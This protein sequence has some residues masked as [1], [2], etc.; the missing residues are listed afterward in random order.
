MAILTKG[1]QLGAY[2]VGDLVGY[3]GIAEV[4]RGRHEELDRDVA[5][6]V[7]N[8]TFHADPTFPLRFRR[9][10]KV[11]ARLSHPNIITVYDFGDTGTTAYLVMELASGDMSGHIR[12]LTTLREVVDAL[13]PVFEAVAYAHER[14]VVH[15]DI[16]PD[17]VL[18]NHQLRPLLADFG[19]ARIQAESFDADEVGLVVGTPYF[20]APEQIQAL[21]VDGR[22]DIYGLGVL[23]YAVLVGRVPFDGSTFTAVASQHLK[24]PAPSLKADLPDAP[25]VLD[26]AVLRA[27]AKRPEDRYPTAI[28]FYDD[29]RRAADAAPNLVIGSGRST[30]T[31]AVLSASDS[32]GQTVQRPVTDVL[33]PVVSGAEV[34]APAGFVSCRTCESF[35][36]PGLTF[37]EVCGAKMPAAQVATPTE[38]T[39]G[40]AVERPKPRRRRASSFTRG[41]KI[42]LSGAAVA[43]L[44]VNVVGVWLNHA[45][46]ARN[47]GV[48]GFIFRNLGWFKSGMTLA[49][50]VL[51]VLASYDMWIVTID[52][53]QRRPETYRRLRQYHRLMGYAA[54]MTAFS[55]GLI[56]CVGIFGFD[57]STGRRA[58][59]SVMG[60]ALLVSIAAKIAVVRK[61]KKYRR[62]LDT[63]GLIVLAFYVLV[64]VTSAVPWAWNQIMNGSGSSYY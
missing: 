15:R 20:M 1:Q 24:K 28:A 46:H 7:L 3:G 31:N 17:N 29:L 8:P 53:R 2:V 41:Q 60:V 57:V 5:I 61:A 50:L 13:G 64:F 9:E 27:M 54:A 33:T 49:A 40:H 32:L 55:I 14:G 39:A 59:H 51:A 63:V 44:F 16:K 52:P 42:A 19:L 6:K 38:P 37:C 36:R 56:T 21:D 4:Y 58:A 45:K 12:L 48:T 10:A 35:V 25:D 26:A 30:A 43:V 34:V 11:T 62:Y 18:L 23:A 47:S 22:A